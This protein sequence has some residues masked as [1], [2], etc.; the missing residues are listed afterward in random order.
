VGKKRFKFTFVSHEKDK[1]E[2]E[3]F[4]KLVF[5]VAFWK[6]FQLTML[7]FGCCN[8]KFFCMCQKCFGGSLKLKAHRRNPQENF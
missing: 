2:W 7:C 3:F 5:A 8:Y 4:W 6:C 1:Q